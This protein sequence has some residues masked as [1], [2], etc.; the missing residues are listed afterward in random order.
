[1]PSC[2][3]DSGSFGEFRLRKL[4]LLPPQSLDVAHCLHLNLKFIY[5]LLT[6]PV[7]DRDHNSCDY[8]RRNPATTQPLS[9]AT[10]VFSITEIWLDPP[11]L[12]GIFR[13]QDRSTR[14]RFVLR[15]STGGSRPTPS[16][17]E[18]REPRMGK[19][20]RLDATLSLVPRQP[21]ATMNQDRAIFNRKK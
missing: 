2:P 17:G 6:T 15:A 21:Q 20:N 4:R 19:V 18:I 9:L 11:V 10:S 12:K 14:T 3:T 5:D 1:M 7:G 8:R 16:V 13:S